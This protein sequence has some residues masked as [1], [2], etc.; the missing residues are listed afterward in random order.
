MGQGRKGGRER[1]S[2]KS[3]AV[4]LT[5]TDQAASCGH[6]WLPRRLG[7]IVFGWVVMCTANS[8]LTTEEGEKEVGGQLKFLLSKGRFAPILG[9]LSESRCPCITWVGGCG[10]ALRW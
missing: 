8:S 1:I 6:A 10:D 4:L 5:S 9:N 3:D 7:N 2:S